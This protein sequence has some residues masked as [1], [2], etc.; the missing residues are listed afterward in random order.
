MSQTYATDAPALAVIQCLDLLSLPEG[1]LQQFPT[2]LFLLREFT[3]SLAGGLCE[4]YF[5]K[6]TSRVPY[7]S[8][9]SLRRRGSRAVATKRGLL[10][11][12]HAHS[13]QK[14]SRWQQNTSQLFCT[15]SL[16][17]RRECLFRRCLWHAEEPRLRRSADISIGACTQRQ[18]GIFPP[19]LCSAKTSAVRK[20]DQCRFE[21]K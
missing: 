18:L 9:R 19:D 7:F 8:S 2:R 17:V 15:H 1:F 10:L 12:L 5:R 6:V 13:D 3:I 20:M 14:G 4:V 11:S 21:F 16:A